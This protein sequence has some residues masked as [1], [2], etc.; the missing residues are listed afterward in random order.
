MGNLEV[1]VQEISSN[2]LVTFRRHN[3]SL[4]IRRAGHREISIIYRQVINKKKD[5]L[6]LF[7][8]FGKV[9]DTKV[10]DMVKR[11]AEQVMHQA[12]E[13]SGVKCGRRLKILVNPH[14]GV[15]K[16]ANI[17]E[18]TVEPIFRFAQC[19]SDITYTTHNRHAYEIA[20]DLSLDYDAV[21]TVSGDGIV[22]EVLNGFAHHEHPRKAFSIPIAPIPTGSGNGLALNILG[23]EHGFDAAEAALNAIKGK[24]M[25]VD[26]FSITQGG[27]RTISFMSQSL[28]LVADADIGTENL[29]WMGDTRFLVGMLRGIVRF[30]SCPVQLSYKLAENDK[31]KMAESVKIQRLNFERETSSLPDVESTLPPLQYSIDDTDGWVTCEEPFLYLYAGKGPFVS[32]DYMVFPVS[33]PNDGLIDILTMR[34]SSRKDALI[35]MGGAEKGG[36]FWNPVIQYVK[37]HAYRVKPYS[38]KGFFSID[39]EM[40]PF[41]EFQVE[42][43]Q[44]LATLLSPYG[45]YAVDLPSHI[46]NPPAPKANK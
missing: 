22:H 28:G 19:I 23:R 24:P 8:V 3:T 31:A 11:W 20:K 7:Y 39:G 41:E 17:F 21:V 35:A 42:V 40:Y 6:T 32:R 36:S 27:K 45:R 13:A 14:G 29:R 12:Y 16:G 37:A 1:N 10:S 33:L 43:H 38:K 2:E 46:Q 9:Q 44:N 4:T 34:A 15:K 25:R 5:S 26:V 18:K 30:K